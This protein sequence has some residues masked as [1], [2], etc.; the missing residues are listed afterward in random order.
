MKFEYEIKGIVLNQE[1]VENICNAYK[2]FQDTQTIALALNME[3]MRLARE[4]A[5]YYNNGGWSA[6]EDLID[7]I[8]KYIYDTLHYYLSTNNI[9]TEEELNNDDP[10]YILEEKTGIKVYEDD[11]LTGELRDVFTVK[12][13][14]NQ[15]CENRHNSMKEVKSDG[16][17]N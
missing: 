15:W 6:E 1:D 14:R 17:N 13:M 4:I 8:D 10:E 3:D 11:N 9:A 7:A 12:K 2:W 5:A 16:S